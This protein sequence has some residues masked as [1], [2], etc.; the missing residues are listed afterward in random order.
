MSD[1][2]Q[3][4][5]EP[6]ENYSWVDTLVSDASPVGREEHSDLPPE[7][8]F[9][10]LDL[11]SL[12]PFD[13]DSP[14]PLISFK[15]SGITE[16]TKTSTQLQFWKAQTV[17]K[18][19][20]AAKL[21]EIGEHSIAAALEHCHS[22]Q[23]FLWCHD[24][25]KHTVYHNRCDRFYCPE[26]QPLL[27]RDRK[28]QVEWWVNQV[29]Q[30]KHVVL[31]VRNYET[32]SKQDVKQFKQW[33]TKLRGL[34][35]A[36]NWKGGFYSLEC[37]NEGKG[38]HV[39]LHALVDAK[40]IC[41]QTLSIVWEHVTE[42]RGYIVRVYDARQKNYLAEVTKYA[43][44]GSQLAQW[45]ARDIATFIH[46]FDGPRKFGVFGSCYGKREQF[47][48]EMGE[49]MKK[50]LECKCGSTNIRYFSEQ[51]WHIFC[52]KSICSG[53][54]VSPPTTISVSTTTT[55]QSMQGFLL[56]LANPKTLPF[57]PK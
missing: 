5:S 40:Y 7:A 13:A 22:E 52:S 37:T 15:N 51:D 24:C 39:H 49:L 38:F 36:K 48:R 31:T 14:E 23:S 47:K 26:C 17:H 8:D 9:A 4:T 29:T 45:S 16:E 27:S 2:F 42:G 46:A 57:G 18:N 3:L 21:H 55:P 43:V 32:L 11:L 44:K 54:G 10:E 6:P 25:Q 56:G 20:I 34:D 35:F 19:T 33:F 30:P 53:V 41:Q 28:T 50:K 12:F 1:A